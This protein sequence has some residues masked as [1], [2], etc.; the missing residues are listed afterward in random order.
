MWTKRHFKSPAEMS[1]TVLDLVIKLS[2]AKSADGRFFDVVIPGGGTPAT[3]FSMLATETGIPW[4]MTRIFWTDERFVPESDPR[5]NYA[6]AEKIFIGKIH[7]PR[8]N[9]F[10]I[11]TSFPSAHDAAADYD[12]RLKALFGPGGPSFDLVIAGMGP[13]GHFA[14]LFPGSPALRDNAKLAV[15]VPAPAT[16]EPKVERISLTSPVFNAGKKIIFMMQRSKEGIFDKSAEKS[17]ADSADIS[18]PVSFLDRGLDLE[19]LIAK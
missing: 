14:S 5:S 18:L 8:E 2:R 3:L 7:V 19:C 15:A 1:E 6:A 12:R 11:I 10:R 4:E 9:V 13:D 17:V 16:C